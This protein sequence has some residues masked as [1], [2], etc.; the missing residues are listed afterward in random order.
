MAFEG[1]TAE[2]EGDKPIIELP[3]EFRRSKV[4]LLTVC[5]AAILFAVAS[6]GDKFKPKVFGEDLSIAAWIISVGF[7]CYLVYL[8]VGFEHWAVRVTSR[9]SEAIW[10]NDNFSDSVERNAGEIAAKLDRIAVSLASISDQAERDRAQ[11]VSGTASFTPEIPD[12]LPSQRLYGADDTLFRRLEADIKHGRLMPIDVPPRFQ[13]LFEN[14]DD[15]F[16]DL[17]AS[18]KGQFDTYYSDALAGNLLARA[19][20]GEEIVARSLKTVDLAREELA[21]LRGEFSRLSDAFSRRERSMYRLYDVAF[22][23]GMAAIAIIATLWDL[24]EDVPRTYIATLF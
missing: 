22:T 17:T 16:A 24:L 13:G 14:A 3:A 7:I 4:T 9:H 20:G 10:G 21:R 6:T 8:W 2:N 18:L 19:D 12:V 23:R 5:A 15:A 1:G 11:L